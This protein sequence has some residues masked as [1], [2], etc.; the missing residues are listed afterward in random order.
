MC[1]GRFVIMLGGNLVFTVLIQS[2]RMRSLTLQKS[3]VKEAK[4]ECSITLEKLST[5]R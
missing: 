2:A 5:I 4:C 3:L 1:A